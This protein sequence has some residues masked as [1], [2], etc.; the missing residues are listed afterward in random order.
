MVKSIERNNHVA[1]KGVIQESLT[2][3]E[4]RGLNMQLRRRL[5]LFANVVHI[6]VFMVLSNPPSPILS[7]FGWH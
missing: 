5:D 7:E 1:L 3:G 6:K 2:T 4:Q